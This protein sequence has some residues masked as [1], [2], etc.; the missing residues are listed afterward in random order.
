MNKVEKKLSVILDIISASMSMY[1]HM[2]GYLH[3]YV[4]THMYGCVHS[5]F[6]CTEKTEEGMMFTVSL[7]ISYPLNTGAILAASKPW[8]SSVS[9][10]F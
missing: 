7:S 4:S 9:A 1:A 2:H 10:F 6:M 8:R 5:L 3:T